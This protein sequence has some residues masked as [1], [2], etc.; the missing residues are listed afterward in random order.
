MKDP[1]IVPIELEFSGRNGTV[2]LGDQVEN[3]FSPIKNPVTGEEERVLIRIPGGM[4]YSGVGD[5]EVVRSE[6]LKSTDEIGFDY[7]GSHTSLVEEQE[8]GNHR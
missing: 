1:A 4:E 8:F 3:T 5:A 7:T 2:K 6:T